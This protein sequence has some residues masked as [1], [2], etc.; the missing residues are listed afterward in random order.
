MILT[1]NNYLPFTNLM[2]I[3]KWLPKYNPYIRTS[4]YFVRS[5]LFASTEWHHESK[6]KMRYL[7]E[8]RLISHSQ[9]AAPE[10]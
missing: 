6:E 4:I 7:L 2:V 8:P 5:A 10:L 3:S 9:A 1:Y